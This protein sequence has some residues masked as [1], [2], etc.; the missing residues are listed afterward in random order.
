MDAFAYVTNWVDMLKEW[1]P[2]LLIS[3][4]GCGLA[5]RADGA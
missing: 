4:G 5:R 1:W 2:S 3:H